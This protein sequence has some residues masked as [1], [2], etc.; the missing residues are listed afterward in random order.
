MIRT[1]KFWSDTNF[2]AFMRDIDLRM[3]GNNVEVVEAS[4][5]TVRLEDPPDSVCHFAEQL[6]AVEQVE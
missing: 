2:A 5:T 3:P 4:L 1:Y 6:G